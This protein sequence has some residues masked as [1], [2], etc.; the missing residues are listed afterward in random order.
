VDGKLIIFSAPSGAGKT[1][2]VKHILNCG[3]NFGFSISATTRQPRGTEV[4]GREYYFLSPEDFKKKVE[5][6]E[7][8]EWE[9]VYPGSFYG[10]LKSEVER[11]C[12]NGQHIIFDVDVI[13]GYNIKKIYG[14]QA[15]A[16]FVQPPSIKELQNRLILRSTDTPE[17]IQKRLEKAELEMSY[18]PLFDTIVINDQLD[19]AL[20]EA[21]EKV[22]VFLNSDC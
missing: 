10:T 15:L 2:I 14:H 4:N 3:F 5:N 12:K 13:G 18:A 17:I 8:L 7:F 6:G 21:A 9:E 22:R 20:K 1:T 16:I 19:I 11:I